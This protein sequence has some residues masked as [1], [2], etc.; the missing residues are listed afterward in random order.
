MAQINVPTSLGPAYWEKQRPA[1]AKLAR[2]PVSKL[3]DELKALTKLHIGIDW[4]AFGDDKLDTADKADA[5]MAQLE[6]AAKGRIKAL[7][8]QARTVETVADKFETD[9]KK[10]KQFP[11]EPLAAAGAIAKAAKEYR[12]DI[13]AFL[14]AARKSL[15]TRAA[16]LA[17]Q[18]PK[19]GA[20]A[21]AIGGAESKA[22]K[23]VR[24]RGLDAIRKIK[25]QTPGAKP[26]RFMIVQGKSTVATYIG[27]SFGPVQEKL[28]KSLIPTEAP[29][30]TFKDA[31]GYLVWEKNAVTFVSDVLPA[32]LV[33]K[34][35]L[36]LKKILKLN[37]KLRVRKTS[38]EVEE[39]EGEDLPDDL[40]EADPADAVDRGQASHDFHQRLARLQPD[41]R[42][43][44]AG[45]SAEQIRELVASIAQHAKHEAYDD[46]D[47]ELD[48]IEALLEGDASGDGAPPDADATAMAGVATPP[49][50]DP[51]A[52][53]RSRRAAAVSSLKTVA[54]SIAGAKHA[55]SAKAIIE[56]QA[57]M[58]NLTAEP[59]TLQ[60]V[61][62]LQRYL[63]TDDVVADVSELAQ[64]I[65]T[66][67]LQALS[68]LRTRLAA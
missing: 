24:T 20:A 66:P 10:D 49:A 32:G 17:A 16:A 48:E 63:A 56:I 34:M 47:A 60:Q 18:K 40:L 42:R 31:H 2:P 68:Q 36:W 5:R 51:T 43:A 65:R 67:L 44:L 58:K 7:L 26:F 35:Q 19:S 13:E 30:R 12:A 39:S 59:A 22:A 52:E 27:P 62:E 25:K 38:G 23:L 55:S 29:Y 4:A 21:A 8:E 1:L 50:A 11:K 37:L 9:A 57:V 61:T 3:G 28:L 41:I 33:K 54:A 64:D 6:D 15:A 53:W 45:A 46:A 14:A